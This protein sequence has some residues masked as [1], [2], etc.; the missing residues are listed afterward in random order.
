MF[1]MIGNYE[2]RKVARYEK[3]GLFISTAMVTD[4]DDPYE[5]AVAHPQ[6]NDGIMV[7][8]ESYPTKAA[9]KRGH[10]KWLKRMTA[11]RLPKQL[12]DCRNSWASKLCGDLVF[13]RE[14]E[15]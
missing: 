7:I 11:K 8:V 3:D 4:G 12:V 14:P 10:A 9:A 2:E 6:Y 15:H 5:T 13:E 1:D